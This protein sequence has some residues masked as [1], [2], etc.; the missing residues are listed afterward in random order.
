[1]SSALIREVLYLKSVLL[2]CCCYVLFIVIAVRHLTTIREYL[3][4]DTSL[5]IVFVCERY[6]TV[7]AYYFVY[8]A[9]FVIGISSCASVWICS[10]CKEVFIFSF[11]IAVGYVLSL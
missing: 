9:F 2:C 6:D 10:S 5:L 11:L 8:K 7:R 4:D 3:M 1:M